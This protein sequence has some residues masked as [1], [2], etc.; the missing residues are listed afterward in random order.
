MAS[1]ESVNA[2]RDNPHLPFGDRHD[3]PVE[4]AESSAKRVDRPLAGLFY[5]YIILESFEVFRHVIRECP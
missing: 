1:N 3:L 5:H 4:C 2:L